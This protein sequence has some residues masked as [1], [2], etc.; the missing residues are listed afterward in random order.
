MSKI[1][2]IDG[3]MMWKVLAEKFLSKIEFLMDNRVY[4]TGILQNYKTVSDQYRIKFK[5]DVRVM[6]LPTPFEILK[7]DDVILL[8]FRPETLFHGDERL[9]NTLEKVKKKD[10]SPFYN[11]IVRLRTIK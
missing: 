7:L 4:G 11:K 9:I 8:D 10:V 2:V 3:S 5:G 1:E 6:I